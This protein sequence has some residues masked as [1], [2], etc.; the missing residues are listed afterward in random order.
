MNRHTSDPQPF[1]HPKAIHRWLS[2]LQKLLHV[3]HPQA[4]RPLKQGGPEG[5]HRGNN[6]PVGTSLPPQGVPMV[7]ATHSLQGTRP[8]DRSSP[9]GGSGP[10]QPPHTSPRGLTGRFL[11]LGLQGKYQRGSRGCPGKSPQ[12]NPRAREGSLV[13]TALEDRRSHGRDSLGSGPPLAPRESA[14]APGDLA[15]SSFCGERGDRGLG[16]PLGAATKHV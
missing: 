12:I 13:P 1:G 8:G 7:Q 2:V 5:G 16:S 3:I 9:P 6:W 15:T 4:T 14:A 10:S 11:P